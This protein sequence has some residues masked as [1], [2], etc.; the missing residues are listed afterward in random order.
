MEK[1]FD[2]YYQKAS[3]KYTD[4]LSTSWFQKIADSFKITSQSITL[5]RILTSIFYQ[6]RLG[7]IRAMLEENAPLDDEA[8]KYVVRSC[9]EITAAVLAPKDCRAW[10]YYYLGLLELKISRRNGALLELWQGYSNTEKSMR[11]KKKGTVLKGIKNAREYFLATLSLVGP[12]SGFLTRLALRCLALITGPE[13]DSRVSGMSASILIHTSIG[14][15]SRQAVC[16]ALGNKQFFGKDEF[17]AGEK[18][19]TDLTTVDIF[20]ALDATVKKPSVREDRVDRFLSNLFQFAQSGWRFT[21]A[22]ICPTGEILLT[23]LEKDEAQPDLGFKPHTVCIFPMEQDDNNSLL[24]NPTYD[25]IVKPLDSLI[26]TNQQQLRGI[27]TAS[28]AVEKFGDDSSKRVWWKERKQV[29]EDLRQL[30]EDVERNYFGSL[31]AR[32][33]LYGRSHDDSCDT[34]SSE[35]S[36]S[37][38]V[39]DLTAKFEAVSCTAPKKSSRL[40]KRTCRKIQFYS[41]ADNSLDTSASD[42]EMQ[43]NNLGPNKNTAQQNTSCTFLILDENLHRFPFEGMPSLSNRPVCRLPSLPFALASL[44][45][46]SVPREEVIGPVVDPEMTSYILDPEANLSDTQQRLVP[47]IA[48]LTARHGWNWRGIVGKIPSTQ[49]VEQSL[50]KESGLLLYC[51]HGGGQSCFSRRQVEGLIPSEI[52]RNRH[53][54]DSPERRCRSSLILMGCSSGKLES[55]NRKASASLENFPIYYEPEGITLSYLMAGAPCVVGN[56]WDVTDHDIDRY[57]NIRARKIAY[58]TPH[59]IRVLQ[60]SLPDIA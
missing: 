44:C 4:L 40:R 14:C 18:S 49:F 60:F 48:D 50:T 26:L 5:D 7:G 21:A 41:E 8:E 58:K 52:Q 30:V 51:G 19:D 43:R 25:A 17:G 31:S 39:E 38:L 28:D 46:A 34:S 29:D 1:A 20:G 59:L 27:M 36:S 16:H 12:A 22:T 33:V 6:L 55:V 42:S 45:T 37:D 10:A 11:K 54:S 24:E 47:F 15:T 13:R 35:I 53:H 32:Q 3:R 2:D 23:S 57:G 9:S 56:L